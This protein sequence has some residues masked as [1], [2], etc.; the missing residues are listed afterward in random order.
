MNLIVTFIIFNVL[1][2]IIQTVKSICTVKCNKWVASIVNAI[3]YGLYTYIVVLTVCDLAL[4]VKILVVALANL[5]G[6]FIVK[7]IEEKG[8]KDKMWKIEMCTPIEKAH[9][10]EST[11]KNLEISSNY[12]EIGKYVI[13]NCYCNTQAETK[14]VVDLAK[15]NECKISAY[16]NKLL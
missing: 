7:L 3:A 15:I 8:K 12:V 6:V 1:N 5:V 14:K 9:A 13:F 2:V 11:L 16:E 4:W 10:V